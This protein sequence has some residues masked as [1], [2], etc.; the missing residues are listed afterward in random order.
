M[1]LKWFFKRLFWFYEEPSSTEEPFW[2]WGLIE[3]SL[4]HLYRFF[5]ELFK[6]MV[7]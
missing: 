4:R 5:E 3:G 6:E 1:V 2:K 7:L